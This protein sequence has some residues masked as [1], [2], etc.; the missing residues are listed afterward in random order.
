MKRGY[1]L[2]LIDNLVIEHA[3]RIT[4]TDSDVLRLI[5][6]LRSKDSNQKKLKA[7]IGKLIVKQNL[8]KENTPLLAILNKSKIARNWRDVVGVKPG[9]LYDE[10]THLES[11]LEIRL[12]PKKCI[13]QRL[14]EARARKENFIS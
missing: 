11:L 12:D 14:E 9:S 3:M 1:G 6:S 10:L 4:D 13:Y 7:L 2:I 5:N 8:P